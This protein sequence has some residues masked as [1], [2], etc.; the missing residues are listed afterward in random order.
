MRQE[1]ILQA[2]RFRHA[3]KEFAAG[4][5][6]GE[7]AFAFIL[8]AGR[9]SPSSFGF[10]PWR[11]V[12]AQDQRLREQLRVHTWGGQ[13]QIPTASHLVLILARTPREM[14]PQSEYLTH[15]MRDVQQLPE[16]AQ[17]PKRERFRTFLA[18]DF[19]LLDNAQALQEWV[20][21]QT[22]IALGNMMTAAALVG[23]DSC[24]LEG[25]EKRPVEA[26][27]DEW[28]LLEDGRFSLACMVA[29][30]FRVR[31]PRQKTRRCVD[32]VI[33]WVP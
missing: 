31:E 22:Y 17:G 9:L 33:R 14:D 32:E 18:H 25:F 7:E 24:P 2:F 28:H 20:C 30:G 27:L 4:R 8:E 10:E 15:I 26:V 5:T 3:T 6:I 29:F 23:V 11:F 21:R 12:V 16:A 13:Q 1:E 19:A